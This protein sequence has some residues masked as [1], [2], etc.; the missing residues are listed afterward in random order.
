MGSA[1]QVYVSS[2]GDIWTKQTLGTFQTL[3]DI[4][5]SKERFQIVGNGVHYTSTD[6]STWVNNSSTFSNTPFLKRLG[7]FG[8]FSVAFGSSNLYSATDG[9]NYVSGSNLSISNTASTS[10]IS[11]LGSASSSTRMILV[12]GNSRTNTGLV[13]SGTTFITSLSFSSSAVTGITSAK[14]FYSVAYNNNYFVAV[15]DSGIIYYSRDGNTWSEATSGV[16]K[17]I[18]SIIFANNQFVA[19]GDF[20]SVLFSSDGINWTTKSLGSFTGLMSV[21]Y[22]SGKLVG[23][24]ENLILV[25]S[26]NGETWVSK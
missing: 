10:D 5:F 9:L 22:G 11:Y 19:V 7:N 26:D 8:S 25:S 1:G 24:A 2:D 13:L 12:G 14:P 16:S 17:T 20:G 18:R 21:A 4:G 6:G 15:G 23:V 3:N